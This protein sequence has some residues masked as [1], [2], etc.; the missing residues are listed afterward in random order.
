MWRFY[1]NQS[2]KRGV[3]SLQT[4]TQ[5]FFHA[6]QSQ[7]YSQPNGRPGTCLENRQ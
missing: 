6:S 5:E 2:E 3:I 4:Q 7:T 1:L